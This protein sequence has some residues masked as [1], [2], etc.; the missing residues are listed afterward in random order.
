VTSAK[1]STFI[2]IGFTGTQEGI[3]DAQVAAT[4]RTFV[5]LGM[6]RLHHGSC[7]GADAWSHYLARV[8]GV[9]VELHP[10]VNTSKMAPCEMLPG[11][12]THAP[13][14]YLD[15]SHDIID[16]SF[17]LVAT[18]KEEVGETMRSGTWATVRYARKR[19]RPICIIRPSGEV[20]CEPGVEAFEATTELA[21]VVVVITP[22]GLDREIALNGLRMRSLYEPEGVAENA[23]RLV[24]AHYGGIVSWRPRL[25]P[26]VA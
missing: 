25:P 18:P 21:T 19:R 5:E 15:R 17:S 26:V 2:D 24:Q 14:P 10:P 9:S 6:T 8:M 20:Q 16:L 4:T 23:R 1:S 7:V 22:R 3:T 13:R 11:E 12:V